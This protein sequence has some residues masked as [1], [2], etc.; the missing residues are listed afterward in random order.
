[1]QAR[2]SC[3]V[4]PG[5]ID[6]NSAAAP[7]TAPPRVKCRYACDMHEYQKAIGSPGTGTYKSTITTR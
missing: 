7:D 3:G 4:Q 6:S 2:F 1:M 5:F